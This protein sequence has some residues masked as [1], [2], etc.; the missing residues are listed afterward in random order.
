MLVINRIELIIN[1]LFGVVLLASGT[2][3]W[4]PFKF[5]IYNHTVETYSPKCRGNSSVTD[6]GK[7]SLHLEFLGN[8]RNMIMETVICF[9]SNNG[10]C[11]MELINR[12]IDLCKFYKNKRYEPILQVAFKTFENFLTH[13]FTA[14]PINKGIYYLRNV[15][16]N[17][18]SLPP[19]F[20][21]KNGLY[22]AIIFEKQERLLRVKAFFQFLKTYKRT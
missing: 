5:I 8:V 20:P 3:G 4:R 21:E 22:D 2:S 17:V 7:F 18:E 9:E 16:M 11:D 19:I 10:I 14:C 13:W 1:V 12:R 6:S 15:E